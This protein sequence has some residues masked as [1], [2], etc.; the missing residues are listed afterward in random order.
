M[1][2]SKVTMLRSIILKMITITFLSLMFYVFCFYYFFVCVC[3]PDE[4]ETVVICT[5]RIIKT[6]LAR[7]KDNEGEK[8]KKRRSHLYGHH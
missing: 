5:D 4:D 7:C 3:W 2:V 1:C 6:V 8:M